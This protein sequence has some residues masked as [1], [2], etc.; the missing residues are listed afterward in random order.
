MLPKYDSNSLKGC[1]KGDGNHHR[2]PVN[3]TNVMVKYV[4]P[5]VSRYLH[6]HY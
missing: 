2:D 3:V 5:Q 6:V 1:K 4:A